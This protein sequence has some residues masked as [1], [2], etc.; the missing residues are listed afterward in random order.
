[1]A[2]KKKKAKTIEEEE[3]LQSVM[4]NH[5]PNLLSLSFFLPSDEK[6]SAI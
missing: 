1:M 6:E 2:K 5:C 3:E 4:L